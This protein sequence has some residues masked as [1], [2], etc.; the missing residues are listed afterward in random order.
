LANDQRRVSL[1]EDNRM[2]L[3]QAPSGRM[4]AQ[5]P[6][7]AAERRDPSR[8]VSASRSGLSGLY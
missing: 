6:V 3:Q 4:T 8:G 5:I 1:D 2:V 7:Q